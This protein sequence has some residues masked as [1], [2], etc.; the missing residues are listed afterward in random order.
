MSVS[1]EEPKAVQTMALQSSC[2]FHIQHASLSFSH[3]PLIL[4]ALPSFLIKENLLGLS[5]A[6]QF[7][8][9]ELT[10]EL[11]LSTAGFPTI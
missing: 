1:V 10:F 9:L 3:V 8:D 4:S 6:F 7:P 11:S 2:A 5:C